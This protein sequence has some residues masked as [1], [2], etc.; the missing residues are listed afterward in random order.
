MSNTYYI[1]PIELTPANE[2][3]IVNIDLPFDFEETLD[4]MNNRNE[5]LKI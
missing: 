4:D 5:S 1:T 3:Q 2:V